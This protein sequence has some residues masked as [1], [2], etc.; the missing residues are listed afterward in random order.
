[1]N[2]QTS[3]KRT[4]MLRNSIIL[5]TAILLSAQNALASQDNYTEPETITVTTRDFQHIEGTYDNPSDRCGV[6]S[7]TPVY[8]GDGKADV[9]ITLE[10][11]QPDYAHIGVGYALMRNNI[12]TMGINSGPYLR[13]RTA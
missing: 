9:I 10:C 3:Y 7:A 11:P 5:G 12:I 2:Q 1:M 13:I 4:D 6:L 8:K